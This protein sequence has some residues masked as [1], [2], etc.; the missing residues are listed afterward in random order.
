VLKLHMHGLDPRMAAL[1][2][3]IQLLL[4]P[5]HH[6][7]GLL[8]KRT[9]GEQGVWSPCLVSI[10]SILGEG[11]GRLALHRSGMLGLLVCS[12]PILP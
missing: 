10:V 5:L 6:V 3:R 12:T 4:L 11:S 9:G 2:H 8:P 1:L 7:D